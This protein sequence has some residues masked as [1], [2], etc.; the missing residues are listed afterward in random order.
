MKPESASLRARDNVDCIGD[1]NDRLA[2]VAYP[3]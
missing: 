3:A 2:A 1:R